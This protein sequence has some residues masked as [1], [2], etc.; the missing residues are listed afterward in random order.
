MWRETTGLSVSILIYI[1][2]GLQ[3]YTYCDDSMQIDA[4]LVCFRCFY[5]FTCEMKLTLAVPY[6]AYIPCPLWSKLLVYKSHTIYRVTSV[7]GQ[8]LPN[9]ISAL[10]CAALQHCAAWWSTLK[11]SRYSNCYNAQIKSDISTT[12]INQ[13]SWPELRREVISAW[14]HLALFY[15]E[16]T[17]VTYSC[18]EYTHWANC[19]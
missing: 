3:L 10:C 9:T 8:W 4:L 15:T 5:P 12:I 6:D 18:I 2:Q 1:I 19:K 14:Q 17:S 11:T 13:E 7:Q 16:G